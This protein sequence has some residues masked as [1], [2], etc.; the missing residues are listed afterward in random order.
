MSWLPTIGRTRYERES[1]QDARANRT[2]YL[3]DKA[4]RQIEQ[5]YSDGTWFSFTYDEV[6]NRK[7][8][9]DP[10][11][12]TTWTFDALDRMET[13]TN[14]ANMTITSRHDAVGLRSGIT[15]P[16]GGRFTY[17]FDAARRIEYLVNPQRV[18]YDVPGTTADAPP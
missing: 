18:A 15:D 14:P 2:T 16:D 3:Y 9:V 13:A 7:T 4:G 1:R 6:G 8:M 17:S 11:G 5:R 12:T 10:T